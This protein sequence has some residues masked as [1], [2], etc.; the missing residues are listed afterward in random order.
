MDAST[1]DADP[2]HRILDVGYAGTELAVKLTTLA[3]ENSRAS[4]RATVI[5]KDVSLIANVLYELDEVMRRRI[6]GSSG[7]IKVLND[8]G[9]STVLKYSE[10]CKRAFE[11][12]N[13][14]VDSQL[15]M[16]SYP[17]DPELDE[18][19]EDILTGQSMDRLRLELKEAKEALM[20][21]LQVAVL[22]RPRI[23]S[24]ASVHPLP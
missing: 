13:L 24:K 15:D 16:F 12:I 4:G 18:A 11:E 8:K 2:R 9:I 1:P 6:R 3:S 20:L 22:A 14:E 5:A 19:A 10:T 7:N 23:L 21:V 17:G